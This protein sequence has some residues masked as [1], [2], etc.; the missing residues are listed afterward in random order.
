MQY[1]ESQ[2]R[3]LFARERAALLAEEM[4]KAR[5]AANAR[6]SGSTQGMFTAIVRRAAR[7]R[8]S[9]TPASLP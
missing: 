6:Q 7:R 5:A 9:L 1:Y 2:A 3:L 8:R 4:R